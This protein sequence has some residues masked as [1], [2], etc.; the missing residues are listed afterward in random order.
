MTR[1][2]RG[3]FTLLEVLLAL[4]IVAAV[5]TLAFGGLRV[6]IAAWRQGEDR[7]ESLA[8]TR[9]LQVVIAGALAGAQAYLG[10]AR[11]GEQASLQFRGGPGAV[12]FVTVNPPLP[13][14][15]GVAFTAVTIAGQG[16][17]P[18]LVIRQKAMPN[19]EPFEEVEP[20]LTDSSIASVRF[21]YLRPEDGTW[22]DT[23]EVSSDASASGIEAS[24]SSTSQGSVSGSARSGSIPP[25]SAPSGG[26]TLGGS[27]L[28][29]TAPGRRGRAPG[30][31]TLS[32]SA[33]GRGSSGLGGGTLV[34]SV[35]G[36][37]IPRA[38]EVTLTE[39]TRGGQSVTHPPFTVSLR[40]STP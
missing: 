16:A 26:S 3:G 19:F 15:T 38:V 24:G 5:L 17:G 7:I 21:R 27:A 8:H 9:N 32:G 23:W 30:S 6:G 2:G 4:T 34:D 22:T 40:A 18:G 1:A 39:I 28:G 13:A 29:G 14:S 12:Q 33:T 20:S 36:G 10:V 31:G 35:P 25:G 37:S 11:Q